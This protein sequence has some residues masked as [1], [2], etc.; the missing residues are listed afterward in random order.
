MEPGMTTAF[1]TNMKTSR[2]L[3]LVAAVVFIISHFLPAYGDGS[4][5]ACFK[6][7][8][9]MFLGDADVLSGGWF[10]Y[11][12][13]VIANNLFIVLVAALFITKK[14]RGLRLGV[15][16]VCFLHVLSWLVLH[17]LEKPHKPTEIKIGYYLW[18]IAYALLVVAHLRKESS[19]SLETV[20]LARPAA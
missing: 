7:C 9:E 5:F 18:L 16:V 1:V 19:E 6:A 15:S 13:F 4:G 17:V 11:S 14:Y 2:I 3:G 12:G 10:Y 20:P 8:W